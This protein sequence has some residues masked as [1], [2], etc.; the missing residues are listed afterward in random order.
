M[1]SKDLNNGGEYDLPSDVMSQLGWRLKGATFFKMHNFKHKQKD[2]KKTADSYW[3]GKET[4][5][6]AMDGVRHRPLVVGCRK[7][8]AIPLGI[9]GGRVF[10]CLI[11]SV[12]T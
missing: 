6:I 11:S 5:N 4:N 1:H 2:R 8:K 7:T 9:L 12:W 3:E 10:S